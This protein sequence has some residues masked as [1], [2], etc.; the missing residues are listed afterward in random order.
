MIEAHSGK[1]A[2]DLLQK[3]PDIDLLMTDQAM[4]GM[5][6]AQLVQEAT[7]HR[8]NLPVILA[9]GYGELP[10]GF[11]PTVV[12]LSKPFSQAALEAALLQA[13]GSVA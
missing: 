5:T 12:K 7:V 1:A 8:P 9:T 10:P 13:M 4:P 6:G 2:L 3:Y 11:K